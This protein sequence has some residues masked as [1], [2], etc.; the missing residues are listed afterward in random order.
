MENA[1]QNCVLSLGVMDEQVTGKPHLKLLELLLMTPSWP[2]FFGS[3]HQWPV[4]VKSAPQT[5]LGAGLHCSA[6]E[7]S[8]RE[9]APTEA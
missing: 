9:T 8:R 2:D 6:V 7:G 3:L 1:K 4:P 5:G